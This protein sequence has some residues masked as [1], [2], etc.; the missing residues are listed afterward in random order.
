MVELRSKGNFQKVGRKVV[1]WMI[2][3]AILRIEQK[4]GE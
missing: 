4:F 1:D 3:F 2:K